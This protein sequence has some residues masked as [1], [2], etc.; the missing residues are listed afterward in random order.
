MEIRGVYLE[1]GGDCVQRGAFALF[2]RGDT[3]IYKHT[4]IHIETEDQEGT[5]ISQEQ[6]WSHQEERR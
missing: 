6:R 1:I 4:H 3:F 5:R 2:G